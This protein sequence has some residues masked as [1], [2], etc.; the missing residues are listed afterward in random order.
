MEFGERDDFVH[1]LLYAYFRWKYGILVLFLLLFTSV[2]LAAWLITPT[3]ESK[4]YL[5]VEPAVAPSNSRFADPTRPKPERMDAEYAYQASQMLVGKDIA[6]EVVQQFGLGEKKRQKFE[7]PKNARERAQAN[8]QRTIDAAVYAVQRLFGQTERK[9]R[10][11]ADEAARDLYDG[12]FAQVGAELVN[13]TEI[14]ELTVNGDK[15]ETANAIAE[16]M[17]GAL[18]RQLTRLSVVAGRNAAESFDQQL[19]AVSEKQ[20]EAELAVVAFLEANGGVDPA[21]D[22]RLKT[23]E[24]DTIQSQKDRLAVELAEIER[25]RQAITAANGK[26]FPSFSDRM[27]ASGQVRSLRSS[28]SDLLIKRDSLLSELTE[29]H[30]DVKEVNVLIERTASALAD[31][32]QVVAGTV[33]AELRHS[34]EQL[35]LLDSQIVAIARKQ[36]EYARLQATVEEWQSLRRDLQSHVQSMT[37]GSASGLPN[38]VVRVLDRMPVSSVKSADMPSWLIVLVIALIF[39]VGGCMVA[40]PFVEYWRDPIRGPID[41]LRKGLLPLAVLPAPGWGRL[42]RRMRGLLP[43][44]MR[45]RLDDQAEDRLHDLAANLVM[46]ARQQGGKR[47][48]VITSSR[49]GK[50]AGLLG[51]QVAERASEMGCRVALVSICSPEPEDSQSLANRAEPLDYA[52]PGARGLLALSLPASYGAL[53]TCG[54]KPADWVRD[55]DLMLLDLPDCAGRPLERYLSQR[56]DGVVLVTDT[57]RQPLSEVVRAAKAAVEANCRLLGVVLV[58]HS[59]AIP[60]WLDR[61]QDRPE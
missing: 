1:N 9:Q 40:P 38:M 18:R 39:A 19:T 34:E 45:G 47:A 36:V 6:L 10:D 3:W 22:A 49:K 58:G 14:V 56:S 61:W 30:P 7:K 54:P 53:P 51:R 48:F 31:E 33:G 43:P 5:V 4:V 11:W 59:S 55:F 2:F 16:F 52:W 20:Q 21:A 50:D 15:P 25:Q 23:E 44:R 28:Y 29:E 41:L 24:R 13:D 26:A 60:A 8:I 27:L 42:R 32:L 12:L 37:I 17:V 46:Q 35:R 57:R